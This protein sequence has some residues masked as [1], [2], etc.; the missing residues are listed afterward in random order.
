MQ[1]EASRNEFV[2]EKKNPHFQSF[3]IK[4]K[5]KKSSSDFLFKFE[6]KGTTRIRNKGEWE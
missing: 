3:S 6:N 5:Q 4:K 1:E 2:I